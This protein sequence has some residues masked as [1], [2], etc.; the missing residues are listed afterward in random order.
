MIDTDLLMNL[1]NWSGSPKA[2]FDLA[3]VYEEQ[4]QWAAATSFYL[5][6]AEYGYYSERDLV[7]AS[8]L[9]ASHC[10]KQQGN[11]DFSESN[12]LLQAIQYAPDRPEAYYLL[13]AFL[14]KP[15]TWQEAYTYAELGLTNSTLTSEPLEVSVGYPGKIGLLYQKAHAG[16]RVG[17]RIETEH[18]L[19]MI[20]KDPTISPEFRKDC[21]AL[22]LEWYGQVIDGDPVNPLEPLVTN[23]RK[24][25]GTTANHIIDI[26][27]RDGNDA[28]YLKEQLNGKNVLAIDPNPDAYTTILDKHVGI[29]AHCIAISDFIGESTFQK[30]NSYDESLVGCSSLYA[31]KVAKGSDFQGIV[32]EIT[33]PVTT[34][35]QFLDDQG[36]GEKVIDVIKVDTEGYTWQVLQGAVKHLSRI[37]MLH[38]ETE[39]TPTHPNHKDNEAVRQFM[40]YAGFSLVD[41]SYEWGWAIEDQ[42]WV[43]KSLAQKNEEAL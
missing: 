40:E 24:Y 28:W 39:L 2:N 41:K 10:L 18:I 12:G 8:L 14:D 43:N 30:V 15:E 32:E 38:L 23:Y 7:Y 33:V 36:F 25:F 22:M 42:L 19:K 29:Q 4:K 1:A 13:S 16:Y 27:S 37:K 3:V 31:E 26:G 9:K 11:R 35:D 34:L 5:R 6:A 20:L 21:E 17:R